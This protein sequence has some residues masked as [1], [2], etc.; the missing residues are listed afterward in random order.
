MRP[1]GETVRLQT[2]SPGTVVGEVTLYLGTARTASV[3]AETPATVYRLTRPR[4]EDMERD[5]PELAAAVHRLFARLLASRL[6]DALQ[7]MN[8][9]LD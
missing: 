6:T 2:M 9:L 7:T 8:A 1:D 4:L 3:I 5:D